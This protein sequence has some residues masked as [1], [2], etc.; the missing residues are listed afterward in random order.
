MV[1]IKKYLYQVMNR[2]NAQIEQIN[3]YIYFFIR[4]MPKTLEGIQTPQLIF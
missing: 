2:K 1:E 4:E 3:K